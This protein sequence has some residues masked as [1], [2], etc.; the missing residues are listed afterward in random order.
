MHGEVAG[1]GEQ[2]FAN[3]TVRL[4]NHSALQ[5]S[6]NLEEHTAT[7]QVSKQT[8]SEMNTLHAEKACRLRGRKRASLRIGRRAVARG[9]ARRSARW[10]TRRSARRER[11]CSARCETRRSS[12]L[13]MRCSSLCK[14]RRSVRRET[15][16][17]AR[18]ITRVLHVGGCAGARRVR[19]R[20]Q[21]KAKRR[22]DSAGVRR[23]V[24][25]NLLL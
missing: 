16:C 1:R 10:K 20:W 4:G 2:D 14:T 12:R 3:R 21:K 6:P 7:K 17:S 8:S 19:A 22:Q 25:K 15:R 13:E 11:C 18:R 5:K 23:R 9:E 24:C